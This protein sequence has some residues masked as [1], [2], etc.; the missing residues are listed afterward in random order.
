M[1]PEMPIFLQNWWFDAVT[2]PEGKEWNA[3]LCEENGKIIAAMPYHLI[4]KYGFKIIIQPQLTQYNG[5]WIDYPKDIK[6]H[7]RYSFEKQVMD[8]L[9]DQ[10]ENLRYSFFTQNFHYSFMNW[11]PFYWRGFR[12]TTRY[13][14]QIKDLSDLEKCFDN[15][16]YAK[17]KHIKKENNNL[18]IDFSLSANEFY[19]F[20]KECLKQKNASIEYSQELFLSVYDE[21]IKREQ[22]KIIALKDKNKNLHS[23]L[24]FV[25]DKNSAYAMISTINPQ[26]KSDGAS[27]K[28]FWEAIKFVSDKTKVFDFEGSIIK[29]VAQSF[30]QFGAEQVPYFNISKSYSYIFNILLRLKRWK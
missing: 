3:L 18:L 8:N 30:Q 13:T 20:H 23:A 2:A 7:K 24:F 14:Y 17:Q 28:M 21:A 6:L 19:D 16:S 1:Q 25:W 15:F 29:N 27:T 4:K 12:Q 5:I 26:F 11:Q 10:L 22:G 9:I